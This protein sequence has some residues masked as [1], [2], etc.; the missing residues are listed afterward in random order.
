MELVRDMVV[1]GLSARDEL[2]RVRLVVAREICTP[3][4]TRPLHE[5]ELECPS[6]GSLVQVAHAQADVVDPAEADQ[7]SSPPRAPQR[8]TE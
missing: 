6:R 2:E 4:Q 3:V 8:E 5:A 1:A 7:R